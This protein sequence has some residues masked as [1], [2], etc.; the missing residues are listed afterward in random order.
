MY[1]VRPEPPCSSDP[2]SATIASSGNAQRIAETITVSDL[3]SASD[4]RS[5]WLDFAS[6]PVASPS[7]LSSSC[8]P[9]ARAASI[10]MAMG[11]AISAAE[12]R[13]PRP[14]RR[15]EPP[16]DLG[17]HWRVRRDVRG[18][19]VD[20]DVAVDHAGPF[21]EAGVSVAAEQEVVD[22]RD[23]I[24]PRRVERRSGDGDALHA[25]RRAP[26]EA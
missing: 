14:L 3:R 9:A 19:D 15:R 26:V 6:T 11:S 25:V 2:S 17:A 21:R 23:V 18:H 12:T 20:L 24:R 7:K 1:Q 4:T 13:V 10:A 16:F 22:R 5:V 8:L